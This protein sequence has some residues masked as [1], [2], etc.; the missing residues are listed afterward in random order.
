MWYVKDG[1]WQSCMWK[2]VCDK[3][4]CERWCV[5]K[6]YGKD[7][8]W[9]SCVWK[10]VCDKGVCERWC[11]TKVYVKDGVWQSCMWKMVCDKGGCERWCV[12]KLCVKDGVVKDGVWQSCVWKM[13]CDK[14]VCE[15]WCVTK[16]YVKDGVWQ[17]RREA[18][19][20]PGIQ[21]QKQEPHTKMWGKR[22]ACMWFSRVFLDFQW[23]G[24]FTVLIIESP[25]DLNL[26]ILLFLGVSRFYV[27]CF[28]LWS[29]VFK[30][31]WL[32]FM[33]RK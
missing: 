12:T 3:G 21:N 19:K 15:R 18:G 11:D 30:P 29:C 26:A 22:I 5:T 2:M 9:Q 31:W 1:V 23:S 20:R 4:G 10:M 27:G 28:R 24:F 33:C 25:N 16:L 17:R 8:G 6:L 13:V 14:V 7:G 32:N